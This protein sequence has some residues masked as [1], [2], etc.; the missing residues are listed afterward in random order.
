MKVQ[1]HT[2]INLRRIREGSKH[3]GVRWALQAL[4]SPSSI[5]DSLGPA[6]QGKIKKIE[7]LGR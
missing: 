7:E 1:D 5:K 4:S 3:Q 6:V 2:P